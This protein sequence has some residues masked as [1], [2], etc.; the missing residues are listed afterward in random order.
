MQ[1]KPEELKNGLRLDYQR[2]E[3][4]FQCGGAGRK[5]MTT[6]VFSLCV[7]KAREWDW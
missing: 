1:L 4:F 2:D 7:F 5:R 6:R 3:G